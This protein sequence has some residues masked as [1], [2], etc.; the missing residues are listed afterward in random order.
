[1]PKQSIIANIG[2]PCNTKAYLKLP[3]GREEI[4]AAG[5]YVFEETL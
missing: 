4:L 5:D 2:V 3:K 1:M